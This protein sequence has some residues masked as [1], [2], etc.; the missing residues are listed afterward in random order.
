MGAG[1]KIVKKVG[2]LKDTAAQAAGRL[3][4]IMRSGRRSPTSGQKD[5]SDI[6]SLSSWMGD[7]PDD[8]LVTALSI[9][10]THDSGCIDGP[11]GFAKTQNL[12]IAEQLNAGIRFLDIRL[13]HYQNDLHVHHDVV[14]MG[15]SYKDVLR[16]CAE[17]LGRHPSETIM[18]S[19]K[20]E[21][22][23]DAPLGDFA[24]S[25][26]LSR[27][28]RGELE[29]RGNS[30]SFDDEFE[31]QTWRQ[32]KSAPPFYNY[33]DPAVAGGRPVMTA[34]T[35]TSATTLGDVRGRIILLRRFQGE[36]G[37]GFD[38]TYWLDNAAT[39]SSEDERG[40]PRTAAPPIYSIE[41]HYNN[42][43]DKY[44]LA[45]AHIE[46]A[47][48]G[49]PEDLY[50]TFSSA[51]TLRASGH[52]E[53]INPRLSDYLAASPQGRVGIVAM[54]YFEEPRELVSHVITT[55]FRTGAT[56]GAKSG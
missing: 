40:N 4:G 25:E 15:K 16:I 18:M 29:S 37:V 38:V 49:D 56:S 17:F 21:E 20:E 31:Y 42:P 54:D 41:D 5:T 39:R 32:L 26:V 36:D 22:R 13:A 50:I 14:Y 7:L 24:P 53:T 46:K 12:D 48:K 33:A 6:I 34:P 43:D 44:D 30:R 28:L 9:P 19:V 10:G 1:D 3:T 52:S 23:F 45:I 2:E 51:V 27:L 8:A 11:V 35:L 47:M 55:N